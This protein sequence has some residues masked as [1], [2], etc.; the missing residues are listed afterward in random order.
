MNKLSYLIGVLMTSYR[1]N[2]RPKSE[3]CDR[4]FANEMVEVLARA[5]DL[6]VDSASIAAHDRQADL[7]LTVEDLRAK[8]AKQVEMI[9]DLR[10]E[11]DRQHVRHDR[12]LRLVS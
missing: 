2:C 5:H 7:N 4:D 11:L 1:V 8:N 6:G 9:R 10:E 12:L 3:Q